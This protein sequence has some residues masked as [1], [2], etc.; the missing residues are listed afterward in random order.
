MQKQMIKKFQKNLILWY[1]KNG[2]KS[3]PWRN[4]ESINC[5]ERLKEIS[6]AYGIY[7]S[8]IML[9][10]TQVKAVLEKFYF[11]F[12][13][14]FPNLTSIAKASEDELLKAWQGLGYYS[15]ARNLKK[16]ALECI[17]KFDA[18]LPR[19]IK[20]L[21]GLSGIGAYTA[22]AIACFGYNQKVAFVDANIRRVL[23]RLFALKKPSM[24]ELR[25]KA[26]ELLNPNNAFDHNQ[27]LLDIGAL[28]CLPK[29]AKCGICPFYDFC[30]GKFNPE[31]YGQNKKILYE[32]LNLNL[33]L[34][35]FNKKFALQKSQTKL[36]KGMYNFPFFKENEFKIHKNMDFI[37]E[38]KHS[39]TKYRLYIKVYH[40]IL[41]EKT[42]NYEFKSLQ[43]LENIALSALSLKAL[44]LIKF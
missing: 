15:R 25:K 17:N 5:D 29:N 2:R 23:S 38:F 43:E 34:F 10:Q 26:T 18:N 19:D 30:E 4:L 28:I 24:K 9:Q 39:Y 3:L 44:K 7:I 36:Y 37:G 16:A 35:E 40:Q 41:K 1:Q 27:A 13:Q 31:F 14:K 6:K 42:K 32:N 20:A 22:G 12:L 33:F 8:E 21:Q 11:P